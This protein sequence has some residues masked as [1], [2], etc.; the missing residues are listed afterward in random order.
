MASKLE[1]TTKDF[2]LSW[3]RTRQSKTDE[4]KRNV[5]EKDQSQN[6]GLPKTL[7]R[8]ITHVNADRSFP[9]FVAPLPVPERS[10]NKSIT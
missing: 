4:A 1:Q 7:V 2:M 10:S 3:R 5:R 9:S 8:N 6:S